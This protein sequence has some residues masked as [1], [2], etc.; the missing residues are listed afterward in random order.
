MLPRQPQYVKY[1][2]K[3]K[4][5][6]LVSLCV[7]PRGYISMGLCLPGFFF[8]NMNTQCLSLSLSTWDVSAHSYGLNTMGLQIRL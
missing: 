4:Q 2:T 5:N 8:L 1:I 3:Y 7:Q 6:I